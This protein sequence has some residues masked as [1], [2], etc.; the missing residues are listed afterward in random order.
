MLR[1]GVIEPSESAYSSPLLLVKKADGSFRPCVDFRML[2]RVTIFDA[3]PMSNP[4][5]II[6][7]LTRDLFFSKVDCS[8]G[9]WQ[10]AM[11]HSDI[12]KTAFS[13]PSGLF[14]F[15]RMQFELVNAGAS[16]CRMMRK[17]LYDVDGADNY[18]DD[19]IIHTNTWAKHVLV[20]G[21]VFHKLSEA[22]ITVKPSKCYLRYATINF[23]GHRMGKGEI[24][25]QSDKVDKV[26]H[27]TIP[28]TVI[29][30][31][32]FLG[33]TGYYRQIIYNYATIATP[34]TDLTKKGRPSRVVWT[35]ETDKAFNQFVKYCIGIF[36]YAY[37]YYVILDLYFILC[38]PIIVLL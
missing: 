7:S 4:E 26:K 18:V 5:Q 2:N 1:L 11:N 3:E 38:M 13:T 20:L 23:V 12:E 14:Q 37:I 16:Y 24:R 21:K 33:L 31:R 6:S 17:L 35:D 29:Q 8:K 15:L 25:T 28:T 10:I 32:S 27:A 9:Y 19:I 30:V 34:L 22:G 36:M